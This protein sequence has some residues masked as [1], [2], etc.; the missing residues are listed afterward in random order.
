MGGADRNLRSECGVDGDRGGS[1]VGPG[2]NGSSEN[3]E[4][5]DD[6][7]SPPA[8]NKVDQVWIVRKC[9]EGA[10]RPVHAFGEES[11]LHGGPIAG[12][13]AGIKPGNPGTEKQLNGENGKRRN[14]SAL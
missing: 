4:R 14:G 8:V 12:H 6:D 13:L 3:H 7:P 1:A 10:V 2:A 9:E 11:A 5:G